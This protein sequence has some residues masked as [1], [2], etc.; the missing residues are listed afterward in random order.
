MLF[1]EQTS[2]DP[3]YNLATEEFLTK[4][5]QEEVCMLWRNRPSVIIGKNQNTLAEINYDY[6]TAEG[7]SVVRRMSGGGAVFHDLGNINYTFIANKS[8]ELGNYERF[9]RPV[10]AFLNTLGVEASLSGRNDLV[11]EGKKISGNAQYVHKNRIMHH[12][13]LLYSAAS[14]VLEKALRVD[15]EKIKTKGVASVKSRVTNISS[16]LE[17]PMTPQAFM[18]KLADFMVK[19]MPD[20]RYYDMRAHEAAITALC[21]EKYKTWEW[22]FGYSPKYEFMKKRRFTFGGVEVH[23]NI[24]SASVIENAKIYGDFFSKLPIEELERALCGASHQEDAVRSALQNINV[25]DYIQGMEQD[26]FFTLLF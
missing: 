22:N 4:E 10:I 20:C 1:V 21:D 12:G 25:S 15:A 2:T 8:A 14:D 9:T 11:I 17:N 5:M 24:G 18:E 23:L 19:T 13:T 6:V 16:Y 3:Y 26:E 7:I